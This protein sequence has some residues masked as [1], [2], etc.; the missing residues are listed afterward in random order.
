MLPPCPCFLEDIITWDVNIPFW[1]PFWSLTVAWT[2]SEESFTGLAVQNEVCFA[3]RTIKTEKYCVSLKIPK[4]LPED[5]LPSTKLRCQCK[6]LPSRW[7]G[8]NFSFASPHIPPSKRTVY[9]EKLN[10]QVVSAELLAFHLFPS[11][12]CWSTEGVVHHSLFLIDHRP[13]FI[14]AVQRLSLW[15]Y[16]YRNLD[17]LDYRPNYRVV[18]HILTVVVAI[19]TFLFDLFYF[20]IFTFQSNT[21]NCFQWVLVRKPANF[22]C[23]NTAA[24]SFLWAGSTTQTRHVIVCIS[25]NRLNLWR[26]SYERYEVSWSWTK[27]IFI[28]N[29]M[30]SDSVCLCVF[31]AIQY[32]KLF[33]SWD[34]PGCALLFFSGK[35]IRL[36]CKDTFTSTSGWDHKRFLKYNHLCKWKQWC[37]SLWMKM[38]S[39]LALQFHLGLLETLLLNKGDI[40]YTASLVTWPIGLLMEISVGGIH[41]FYVDNFADLVRIRVKWQQIMLSFLLQY[42]KYHCSICGF[43]DLTF[44]WS[45]ETNLRLLSWIDAYYEETLT[46]TYQKPYRR[47]WLLLLL[48]L[49]SASVVAKERRYDFLSSTFGYEQLFF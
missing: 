35:F 23:I 43:C 17:R 22:G 19:L 45:W 40:V 6:A 1:F 33:Q 3:Y 5:P 11:L 7:M 14:Y 31:R 9:S 47:Y 4:N 12:T 29:K 42:L 21:W 27:N 10:T 48:L 39:N 34:H 37:H 2:R 25:V 41:L 24:I 30:M 32:S 20:Q 16:S 36:L 15:R 18:L 46:S 49:L 26:L 38:S 28:C 8:T 13:A 44:A